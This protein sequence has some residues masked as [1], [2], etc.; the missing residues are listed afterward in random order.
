[1]IR[2]T[3]GDD[4]LKKEI[5]KELQKNKG[6]V[7]SGGRLGNKFKVTRAAVWKAISEL[8]SEGYQ[9]ESINNRGY[10]LSEYDDNLSESEIIRNLRTNELGR[11]IMIFKTIDSTN[12]KAKEL[13]AQGCQNGLLIISDEQTAGR[14]RLGKSF[15]SI[16]KKG[17]YMSLVIKPK[18]KDLGLFTIAAAVA[19]AEAVEGLYQIETKIKWVNDIYVNNRKLCGILTESL[20]EVESGRVEYVILGIGINTSSDEKDFGELREIAV[21]LEQVGI[22]VNRNKLAAEVVNKLEDVLCR[23]KN[24]REEILKSYKERLFVLGREIE[25]IRGGEAKRAKAL[26]IDQNGGLVIENEDGSIET[27]TFGEISIRSNL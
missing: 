22:N 27:L 4:M 8:K 25:V 2:Y 15:K 23:L 9:I 11:N 5:L 24:N 17:I 20:V 21:S 16:D 7:L 10:I 14:G 13:A 18:E 12:T 6:K 1:M 3:I 26:D 19:V